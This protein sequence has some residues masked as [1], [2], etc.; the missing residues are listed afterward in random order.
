MRTRSSLS[1]VGPGT[2]R[3]TYRVS[4]LA[5]GLSV[6]SIGLVMLM[7]VRAAGAATITVDASSSPRGN[8]KFWAEMVGTGTASLGLRADLQTH[9]KIA[10]RE[11]GMKR[12][13]GHGILND[14]MDIYRGPG[15][16]NW[17]NYDTVLEGIAAA[18]MRP[19]MELSFMPAALARSG[20]SKDPPGDFDAYSDFIQAVVQRAI[21][22]F[23]ADDVSQW[24]W[25]V[26]NEPNYAGFWTGTMQDYY[27]M[28]DA[29]VAGATAALPNIL[30]GG[31]VTTQGS[32]SQMTEFL[33]HCQNNG[34]RV[35]FLA[36]HA[37]PG[38]SG[39]ARQRYFWQKRQQ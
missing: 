26:W 4:R 38:G 19:G 14:D 20:D 17:E 10:N 3:D 5:R 16:Y 12:V 36:S 34:T 24:Y 27:E 2:H 25:E 13:R 39:P 8:P 6:G 9:F 11:L 28:Y 29:A 7:A 22:L 23:G 1:E 21:D 31:P 33:Q 37:Y 35:S 30:I 15:N 18:G 32:V